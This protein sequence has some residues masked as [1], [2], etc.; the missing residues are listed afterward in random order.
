MEA[1]RV[2]AREAVTH[3]PTIREEC[4]G[5]CT[6]PPVAIVSQEAKDRPP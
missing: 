3:A 1:E 5:R 6:C 2:H 4:F